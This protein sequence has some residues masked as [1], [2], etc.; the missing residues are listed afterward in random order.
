MTINKIKQCVNTIENIKK[1]KRCFLSSVNNKNCLPIPGEG[2]APADILFIG[3]A[4]SVSEEITQVLW[5]DQY[6]QFL[7]KMLS[8]ALGENIS[9]FITNCVMCR[10]TDKIN[11]DNRDPNFY[12][13]SKCAINLMKIY[14]LVKPKVVIFV[15]KIAQEYYKKE[16]K[17]AIFLLHPTLLIN[18]GGF[19]HP[20]Y[21]SE[22]R[23]LKDLSSKFKR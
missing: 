3:S 17:E 20:N 12:E 21:R 14:D 5:R 13:I 19:N 15:S 1:C 18:N 16:F 6:R 11:G 7:N 22:L 2:T 23:K 8:T 10:P 4:P 9:Y